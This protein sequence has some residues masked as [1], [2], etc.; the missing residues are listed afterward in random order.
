MRVAGYDSLLIL[1]IEITLST[2]LAL[3]ALALT[4]TRPGSVQI[5]E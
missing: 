5:E 4:L 2:L 3:L 1:L